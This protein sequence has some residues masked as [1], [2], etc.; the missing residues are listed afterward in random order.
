MAEEGSSE[1]VGNHSNHNS[2]VLVVPG[3]WLGAPNHRS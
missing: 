2:H 3:A 1:A